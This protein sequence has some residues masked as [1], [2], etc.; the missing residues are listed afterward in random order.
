MQLSEQ[1]L[2]RRE[3]LASLKKLGINPYPANEYPVNHTSAKIKQEFEEGK[4]V[5]IAG[6]LMS[7]RI[8]GKAS[9]A[10]L[11]DSQGRIQVYFNRDEICTGEDKTQYN[12]VYKKLL[13]I[14]DFIGIEGEL[15]TTQVGEKTVMVKNFVLLSKALKPLPLP[16]KDKDGNEYDKFND[17]E[18]R[19]RQRYADLAVNSKVKE[20]FI[21]RTKLFT[22]MRDFFNDKGYFEV[23]TPILQSIP[24]GAAAR[25]FITHHNALDIP[26][27]LR[28]ANELYLK[29]LIVGGFDGVYEFSKNFRNE[30]MDRTH[31]PE[32]TV[33]E[34]YVAYKDYNWMM[35]FTEKLLEH[36]AIAVN[37][38]TDA[39]FGEH[40]INFKAPYK[41]VTMTDSIKEF[42]GFD[43]TGK[44]E[45]ELRAAALRMGLD[46]DETMG[47][48][49]LIDEIFG[50]KCEGNYIQPT[51]I[52]DYPKEMS[53]L[54]KE[55]RDNPELTERFE[56]M[57]CGKEIANAYSE[58]NDPI[59]QRERFE[60]QLN[61]AKKGDDEATEFIDQ[62]FLRALEY[63]MPPTSG[64]GIGMDRLIMFL[65]NNPSIQ[66][67]LFFPQM[68]PERKQLDLTEEEKTVLD[69]LKKESPQELE[70]IKSAS[71]LSNKKWDKAT[72]G[73]RKHKLAKVNKTD[74][75]LFVE[76]ES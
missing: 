15:F 32:F 58:L 4:K 71:G 30:G 43:I 49:K 5:V 38:T 60:D 63:G 68:R 65:T 31:N 76:L 61:L 50:E 29:R 54:S 73:L 74:E 1:E 53:P 20:V 13:D 19:Y 24:G 17:P 33:I 64:L 14:G 59:D 12:D 22:A 2:V 39:T 23:E 66:E 72:K 57:V 70:V 7:R 25:P 44:T 37:G 48:G 51:Y 8:Q 6:R 40:K 34:I 46:V 11:Q 26:L 35:D 56:L 55:H 27:Y 3:K 62:D 16:K 18:M 28:I 41:R 10:E 42:T 21:K 9:F 69:L 67:V 36:C 75:G 45:E 52:T 47:K